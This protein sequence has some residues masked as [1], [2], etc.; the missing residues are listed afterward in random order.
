MAVDTLLPK[1]ID[2][3]FYELVIDITAISHVRLYDHRVLLP[4]FIGRRYNDLAL[5]ITAISHVPGP[6]ITGCYTSHQLSKE[7]VETV[8]TLDL[9][10]TCAPFT[11]M[12]RELLTSHGMVASLSLGQELLPHLSPS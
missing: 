10:F 12:S 9:P 11:C 1:G 6:M 7:N 2:K 8:A 3:G 5:E 4:E